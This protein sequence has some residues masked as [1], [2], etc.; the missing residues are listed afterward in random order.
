MAPMAGGITNGKKD[1][2]AF[3]F[4]PGKRFGAPGVPVHRVMCMLKQI[5]AAFPGQAVSR[6]LLRILGR[7]R[8]GA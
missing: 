2:L 1:Q 6:A 5:G 4:G 7:R 8:I 3:L